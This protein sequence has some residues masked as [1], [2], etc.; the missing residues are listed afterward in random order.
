VREEGR[1]TDSG[2]ACRRTEVSSSSS[3]ATA[4]KA[5]VLTRMAAIAVRIIIRLS[6][7]ERELVAADAHVPTYSYE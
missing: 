6:R 7:R 1:S 2:A 3:T 5:T 4:T